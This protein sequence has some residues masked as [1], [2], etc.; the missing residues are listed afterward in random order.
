MKTSKYWAIFRAELQNRFAYPGD[1]AVHSLSIILFMWIFMQLWKTTYSAAGTGGVISGLTLRE[2]MWYLMLAEVI[3]LSKPRIAKNISDAVKDGSIGYLLNKPYNFLL[4]HLSVGFGDGLSSMLF[5]LLAGGAL[6]WWMVGPPPPVQ[7]YPLTLLV[8]CLA[9]LID[10]CI[11]AMIGLAAFVAEE[12]NAFEWIYQKMLFLL[13]GLLIPLDFFPAWLKN[14]ALKLPFAFTVY[15]PAR[16]FVNPTAEAFWRVFGGQVIWLAGLGLL[17]M[18][19]YVR[20]VRRL[21][22]N[23]G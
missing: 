9:W 12:V 8:V 23:G 4:Y 17:L 14:I 16:F 1:L 10:F 18:Y 19:V 13:G 22:I 21:V 15:G 7:G 2:T 11:N 3:V 5:N 6:V 20:S